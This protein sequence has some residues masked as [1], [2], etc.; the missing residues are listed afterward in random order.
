MSA[1]VIL[2]AAKNLTSALPSLLHARP[3]QTRVRALQKI[4]AAPN[5]GDLRRGGV[6]PPYPGDLA[7]SGWRDE[8]CAIANELNDRQRFPFDIRK[9]DK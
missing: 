4:L 6:T 1:T 5:K 7:R 3:W 2:S 9:C 8:F